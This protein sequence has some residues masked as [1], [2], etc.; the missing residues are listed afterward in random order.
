MPQKWNVNWYLPHLK[1]F[2]QKILKWWHHFYNNLNLKI[3]NTKYSYF[4]SSLSLLLFFL[5]NSLSFS[6]HSL[7]FSSQPFFLLCEHRRPP[8]STPATASVATA[9]AIFLRRSAGDADLF[10]AGSAISRRPKSRIF[11]LQNRRRDLSSRLDRI[12]GDWSSSQFSSSDRWSPLRD[13]KLAGVEENRATI[14]YGSKLAAIAGSSRVAAIRAAAINW[15]CG[16]RSAGDPSPPP[17]ASI[18]SV[19][20]YLLIILKYCGKSGKIKSFRLVTN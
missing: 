1:K 10:R 14:R 3:K 7:S 11:Q 19:L 8:L 20:F 5:D 15:I 2:L 16:D 4:F 18:S 9:L 6:T 12:C 13:L 17:P